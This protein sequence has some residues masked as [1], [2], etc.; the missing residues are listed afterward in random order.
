MVCDTGPDKRGT[1]GWSACDDAGGISA[2]QMRRQAGDAFPF[3][4]DLGFLRG[5][6]PGDCKRETWWD[7]GYLI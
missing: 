4:I 2:A 1:A 7:F 5:R 3:W 6:I